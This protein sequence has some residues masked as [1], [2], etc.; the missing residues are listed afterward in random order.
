MNPV[1]LGTKKW[2]THPP[3]HS[4]YIRNLAETL[5]KEKRVTNLNRL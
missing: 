4:A 2:I 1:N 3:D 5:R